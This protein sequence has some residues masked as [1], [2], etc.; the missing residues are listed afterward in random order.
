MVDTVQQEPILAL[1]FC[2]DLSLVEQQDG[3]VLLQ[4]LVAQQRIAQPSP[5]VRAVLRRLHTVEGSSAEQLLETA[6]QH[7]GVS[8]LPTVLALLEQL[9]Q[10]Q[11]LQATLVVAG[12]EWIV[13]SPLPSA[14]RCTGTPSTTETFFQLSRFAYMRN[15]NQ[16]LVLASSLTLS[17]FL[18]RDWRVTAVLHLLA[19]PH[20]VTELAG[21]LPEV[22]CAVISL[23]MRLLLSAH[24]V[25]AVASRECESEEP[26][27]LHQW[28]F[29][30]LLFHTQSRAGRTATSRGA[31]FR[32][33]GKVK[34]LPAVK[35]P[36][37]NDAIPLFQPDMERL[38]L[39]DV[40]LTRVMEE[41]CSTRKHGTTPIHVR[42]L[43]EFLYRT[44]RIRHFPEPPLGIQGTYERSNRPYPSGGACYELELYVVVNAC[45]GLA[46]GLYHYRPDHH[47]LEKIVDRTHHIDALLAEA[48]A[49]A[50]QQDHP[51]ILIILAARFQRVTWKYEAMA[52]ATIL[53]NVGALYQTMY[54]V[55]TA[56]GLAACALGSGN[57][58]R[59][60]AVAGTNYYEETSVG[61]FMLGSAVDDL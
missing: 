40:S 9:T 8:G 58:E 26:S 5:G 23:F 21:K 1:S 3:S 33:L 17:T 53:K 19:A 47:Q 22:P 52:Y 45:R 59:F 32:F 4:T 44:A 42:Q 49:S 24:L 36:M 51:Q 56:M 50:D 12:Q 16:S 57:A 37:T 31:T 7:E 48:S 39:C 20:T 25:S 10:H 13:V 6:F 2:A 35:T 27:S 55:A 11:C 15:E 18:L 41:R 54:L 60:A 46:A 38:K 29:H 34:P 28:E 14:Y 61:E 30:D 43:S